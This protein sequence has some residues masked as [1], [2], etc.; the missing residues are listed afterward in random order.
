MGMS[1][2][3]DV[4]LEKGIVDCDNVYTKSPEKPLLPMSPD[5]KPVKTGD[6]T[7]GLLETDVSP[8]QCAISKPGWGKEKRKKSAS[9]PPRPPRGPSLDAADMKLI[10][11]I[12][13]LA[14]LKRARVERLRALKKSRAAKTESAASS[15]GNVLAS[16]LTAIFF[17]VLVIQGFSPRAADSSST[18]KANGGFVSV[19]YAGNPSASE[20][21]GSYTGPVLARR[22]PNLLKPVSGLENGKKMNRVSQ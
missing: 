18:G 2:D 16:I 6:E 12:A 13:E 4:D 10:R 22:L 5:N 8:V 15:L 3:F 1:L 11:E 20:P 7:V 9:K 17:F 21:G 14:M 19:Q